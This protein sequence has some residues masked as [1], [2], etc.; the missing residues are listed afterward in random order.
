[1]R[2]TLT[3][4]RRRRRVLGSSLAGALV[5]ALALGGLGISALP[6]AAAPDARTVV[7]GDARFQVLSPHPD[8]HRVRR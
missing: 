5:G 7:S 8:P 3:S 2:P 6:A 1:M 4:T